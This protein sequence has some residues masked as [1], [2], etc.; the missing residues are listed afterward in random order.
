MDLFTQY[1]FL[2]ALRRGPLG[3]LAFLTAQADVEENSYRKDLWT[4]R[5][6]P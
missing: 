4:A 6:S 5:L 3:E 2:S 1:K